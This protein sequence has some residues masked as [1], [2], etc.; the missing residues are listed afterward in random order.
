MEV[1]PKGCHKTAFLTKQGLFKFMHMPFG[2]WNA[3]ASFQRAV[4]LVFHGMTWKEIL[5]YLDD[6]NVIGTGFHN[7]LQNL[8][9]SFEDLF[10]YNL[11]LKPHKCCLFQTEV[12]FWGY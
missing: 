2:L 11:K 10:Q 1:H 6:L 8:Q 7:H 3:A 5:T 12:P 9:R 4:Q